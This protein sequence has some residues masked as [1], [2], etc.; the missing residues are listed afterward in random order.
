MRRALLLLVCSLAS[1]ACDGGQRVP[2][3]F[4]AARHLRAAAIGC[5]QLDSAAL[6]DSLR[7]GLLNRIGA[8]QL[9]ADLMV[10]RH[11]ELRRVGGFAS[12]SGG[13][14]D[15]AIGMWSA[16]SLSDSIA[17]SIGDGFNGLALQLVPAGTDWQGGIR[18]YTDFG[19]ERIRELGPV[20][21]VR[22]ACPAA[23]SIA[24]RPAN[25]R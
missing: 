24:R 4:I 10:P 9:R 16:D 11:P 12:R 3:Q 21:V 18:G 14:V 20:R 22:I 15:S 23:S 2:Q 19:P 13:A 17:V 8:L 25:D 1:G 6:P 7:R 5:Y